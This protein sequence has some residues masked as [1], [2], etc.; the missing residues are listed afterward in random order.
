MEAIANA[1]LLFER[2]NADMNVGVF[3]MVNSDIE[4]LVSNKGY[5]FG[6]MN[7]L[8]Y[9]NDLENV[10]SILKKQHVSKR[11]LYFKIMTIENY[12]KWFFD[13]IAINN[14]DS[15]RYETISRAFDFIKPRIENGKNYNIESES[16][17]LT[18]EQVTTLTDMVSVKSKINPFSEHVR[19]R[20]NLIIEILL[21]TGIRGGELLNIK[22]VDFDYVHKSLCIVR[23]PDDQNEPRLRQPLVKTLERKIPLSIELTELIQ[24]YISDFRSKQCHAGEHDYLLVT[25]SSKGQLGH[26]LTISGYQKIFEQIRKNSNVLS[27]IVGHSLRHTWNVKFSEMMLMN[28]NSQD[29][30]TYEKV[31]NYLM[32]WKKNSS[33]SDIYN[34]AFIAQE[35]RKIMA[36][37]NPLKNIVEDKSNV[38]NSKKATRKSI[39]GF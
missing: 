12:V 14:I 10:T 21:E 9:R 35:S 39:F 13:N 8:S 33:T 23:R 16:K 31:R 7:A 2:Y 11:T 5:L 19:F 18:N 28:S 27:D 29:Y 15:S 6:L 36:V 25:H 3:D 34:Q 30:I 26:A 24:N 17:S 38:S 37:I 20:N 1:L 32:G 4:K 22:L